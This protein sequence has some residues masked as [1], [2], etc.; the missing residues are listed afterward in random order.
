MKMH[1]K[2]ALTAGLLVLGTL[3]LTGCRQANTV[4]NPG[5]G[6]GADFRNYGNRWRHKTDDFNS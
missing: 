1:K 2:A 3:L 6:G 4:P 5:G